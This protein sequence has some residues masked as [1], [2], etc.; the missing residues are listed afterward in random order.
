M[1][2]QPLSDR[3]LIEPTAAEEVTASGIIIPDS[4]KEKPLKGTVLA[5]KQVGNAVKVLHPHGVYTLGVFEHGFPVVPGLPLVHKFPIA[6]PLI[7][8]GQT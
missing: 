5:V 2:I 1:N 8:L 3:V 6:V 7:P 4:A